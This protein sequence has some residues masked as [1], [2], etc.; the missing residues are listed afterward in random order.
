[1]KSFKTMFTEIIMDT[2]DSKEEKAKKKLL[3]KYN[4]DRYAQLNRLQRV[5]YDEEWEKIYKYGKNVVI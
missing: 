3:K 1:M 5:K 4:V 2:G